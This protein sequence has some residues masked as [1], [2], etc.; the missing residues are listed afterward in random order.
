MSEH[1]PI[2]GEELAEMKSRC[3]A[4]TPG[5]WKTDAYYV[6]GQ[7]KEGRPGGEV[8]VECRTT[9]PSIA[10]KVNHIANAYAI[11]HARTD[12]PYCIAEIERLYAALAGA[13]RMI[14]GLKLILDSKS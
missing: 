12:L 6:V 11:A 3:D 4:A 1:K 14:K 2:T 7:V 10:A 13:E 5:P 8:I 9:A